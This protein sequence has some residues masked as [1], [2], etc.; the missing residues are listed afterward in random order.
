ME[1]QFFQDGKE[2]FSNEKRAHIYFK[3]ELQSF[4]ITMLVS[5]T[6]W[7]WLS[8]KEKVYMST[9][10]YAN[11][12]V[13]MLTLSEGRKMQQRKNFVTGDLSIIIANKI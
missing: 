7:E 10:Y 12:A 4:L 5:Q 1:A 2:N 13:I 9:G 8:S 11:R 6:I 3:H